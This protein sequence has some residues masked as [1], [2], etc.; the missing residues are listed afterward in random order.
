MSLPIA[1]HVGREGNV[2]GGMTQVVNAYLRWPFERTRVRV[3][4]SRDGSTGF[5]ALALFLRAVGKVGFGLSDRS[6]ELVVV[7]LSQRG[8]FLREGALLWLA[9]LRG[10]GTVAHLHGSSFVEFSARWPR[11]VRTALRGADRVVVLSEATRVAAASLIGRDRVAL[12]PNAVA[13]GMDTPKER[14][15]VFGGA[16][17]RRKGVDVLA[18][19][20]HRVGTGRGW[21][22]VVAGPIVE[23]D[24]VPA[25]LADASFVGGLRHE[26]L[27]AWLERSSIAVLPSRD[28]AMP[29]FVLEAM[30][31]SNCVI[32]TAVGGI[33]AVL[34]EG[35]GVLV[36]PADVDALA[37]ALDRAIADD[38]WRVSTA[39]AGRSVFDAEYS[40]AIVYPR[41]E[42]LWLDVLAARRDGYKT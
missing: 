28:E 26:E 8:S 36:A 21:R 17:G 5:R 15:V 23:P 2:A 1:W 10:F 11:L 42:S 37:A 27:M 6:R 7:H 16:V 38:E 31:R 30:A 25:A 34:K 3:I 9:R 32:A 41:V 39:R 40:A 20:W 12:L 14:L 29:M 24:V 19:A 4:H 13:A 35:G 33:P 18:E 22:L